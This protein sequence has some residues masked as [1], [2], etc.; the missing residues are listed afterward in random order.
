MSPTPAVSAYW[1]LNVCCTPLPDAGV[2]ETAVMF[3]EAA[4]TVQVPRV[5]QPVLELPPRPYRATF[6]VPLKLDVKLIARFSTALVPDRL[7]LLSTQLV[8][9][10]SPQSR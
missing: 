5:C 6:L 4:G 3:A 1:K 10:V 7:A 2:T 8:T 9:G